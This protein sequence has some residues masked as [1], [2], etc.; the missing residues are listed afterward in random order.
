MSL[1]CHNYSP[2]RFNTA[3]AALALAALAACS[4]PRSADQIAAAGGL[5]K[6]A[7]KAQT[8]AQATGFKPYKNTVV[9]G[10]LKWI[11]AAESLGVIQ[12]NEGIPPLPTGTFLVTRDT[13]QNTTGILQTT[14][15][16]RG[17]NQGV[18]LINGVPHDNDEVVQPGPELAETV[19][20]NITLNHQRESQAAREMNAAGTASPEVYPSM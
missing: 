1:F 8:D 16:A 13:G 6:A 14:A 19:E 9:V 3:L 5:D 4:S 7:L 11:S 10:T 17:R 2:R 18:L 12:Y 20:Y 15:T